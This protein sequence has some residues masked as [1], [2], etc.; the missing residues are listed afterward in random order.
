MS[1]ALDENLRRALASA[2]RALEERVALA[3]KLYNQAKA[4]GHRLLAENW[5]AKLKEFEREMDI[6]RSSI[7]RMD[8][9]A[10]QADIERQSAA[11]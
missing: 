2:L 10:A 7:R 11:E 8:R 4:G 5:A 1:L 9:L 6:I 3:Q